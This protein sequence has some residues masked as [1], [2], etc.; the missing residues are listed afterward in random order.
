MVLKTG[1]LL[2]GRPPKRGGK[3]TSPYR[4]RPMLP[5]GGTQLLLLGAVVFLILGIVGGFVWGLDRQLRGGLLAQRLEAQQRPDW[6]SLESIP[7]HVLEAFLI[8]VDPWAASGERPPFTARQT[9]LPRDLVRQVHLLDGGLS[10]LARQLVL[11]PLAEQ[12]LEARE[13]VELYMNRVYLGTSDDYD[14]F[15]IYH[16]ANEYFGKP[17]S[18]LTLSEGATL[19]GLL[20]TPPLTR[21]EDQPGAAGARRNEVLRSLLAEGR[22]SEEQFAQAIA[23]P[24]GFQPWPKELPVTRRLPSPADTMPIRVPLAGDQPTERT[25]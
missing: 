23:E 21:P 6:A 8:V 4:E 10:D 1:K 5:V 24:L 14:V 19:A 13:L 16:A 11:T 15:G 9:N 12:R 20:L 3:L 18:E 17:Y 25:E 22:I 2:G 7:P